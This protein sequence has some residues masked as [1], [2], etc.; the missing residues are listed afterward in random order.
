MLD[1]ILHS[2]EC[3]TGGFR[4]AHAIFTIIPKMR[5]TLI[6][7][8]GFL[9]LLRIN[10]LSVLFMYL[11]TECNRRVRRKTSKER[12]RTACSGKFRSYSTSIYSI[13]RTFDIKAFV[14][15]L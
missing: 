9:F 1:T 13:I 15:V 2:M 6:A 11:Y 4:E 8:T 5:Q 3:L 10:I 12:E 14:I 7:L